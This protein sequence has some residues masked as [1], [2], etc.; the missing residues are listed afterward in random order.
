[1]KLHAV[2]KDIAPLMV[3]IK[4]WFTEHSSLMKGAHAVVELWP[5]DT[6]NKIHRIMKY[7]LRKICT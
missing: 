3:S 7:L 4:Y 1:M 5:W 6:V 2:C